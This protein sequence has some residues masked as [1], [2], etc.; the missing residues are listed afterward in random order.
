MVFP[1]LY[2]VNYIV[3]K[4]LRKSNLEKYVV[5]NDIYASRINADALICGHSRAY[6]H[7]SPKILDTA[8]HINSYNLGMSGLYFDFQYARFR[9]YLEHNK[10]PKYI[11]QQIDVGFFREQEE[12]LSE[13]QYLP[14]LNDSIIRNVTDKYNGRFTL[15]EKYIPLF[16]YNNHFDLISTGI[17]WYFNKAH[18]EKLDFYKGYIPNDLKWDSS[19]ADFKK[20][21]PTGVVYETNPAILAEFE[22]YLDYC[23]NNDIKVVFVCSPMYRESFLLINNR[24]KIMDLINGYARKYN[25][26]FLDYS[27]DSM[28]YDK[29]NFYNSQHLTKL[30]SEQFSLKLANDLKPIIKL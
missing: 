5:W 24:D 8:L 27:N 2:F 4:G 29:N 16:K 11:I 25:I 26:P 1:I 21:H 3:D 28:C 14:Y 12:L 6:R 9:I 22:A 30:A 13:T 7:I 10:K 17:K 23:K 20:V 15:P 19:F 18:K